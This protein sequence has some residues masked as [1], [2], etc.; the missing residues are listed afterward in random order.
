[1]IGISDAR[2][3][4]LSIFQKIEKEIPPGRR[5][6]VHATRREAIERFEA[7]GF[8]TTRME[9]WRSTSVAPIAEGSFRLPDAHD[10]GDVT[11]SDIRPFRFDPWPGSTLVFVNG[12]FDPELSRIRPS[13]EGVFAGS[14]AEAIASRREA[15][16]P[17]LARIARFADHAFT[18]LN[19]AFLD[20]G[21]C[22]VLPRS[23]APDE[24]IHIL[25]LASCAGGVMAHPRTLI[26]AGE[27]SRATLLETYAGL[28]GAASFTNAVTEIAAEDG[29]VLDHYR[30]QI[31]GRAAFHVSTTQALLGRS[32]ALASH[33]I[34]LG[35]ALARNDVVVTL[36]GEGADCTLNGLYVVSGRQHVDNHTLI[37]HAKPHGS[38][39][40]LYKGVLG[41][42]SRGV[43][44]GR[45]IVRKDAQKTDARQVN[46]NMLL[47]ENALVDTKPQL[48]INA[49]DVKCTHAATIGQLEPDKLFYLRA[50]GLDEAAARTL[51]TQGFVQDLLARLR[52]GVLRAGLESMIFNRFDRAEMA[53]EV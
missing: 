27:G 37:D 2:D 11:V 36:A 14:L 30:V 8:P 42:R 35:G 1:M 25:H 34:S 52:I 48:E 46:R 22:V 24:P 49:D 51:L 10:A 7:L 39:R 32:A 47:S 44:D 15:V 19:T 23:A 41:G 5:P 31:E 12:C 16:E 45:I 33:S 50:R 43:F 21:A 13:R 53:E 18:A 6:W 20:D 4:Y 26:V 9:D 40:Q 3:R 29:A 28:D 17:H 38:S